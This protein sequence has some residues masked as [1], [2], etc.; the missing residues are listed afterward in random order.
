[1]PSMNEPTCG[2]IDSVSGKLHETLMENLLMACR[3]SM[4]TQS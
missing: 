3:P 1:M 2:T 4:E